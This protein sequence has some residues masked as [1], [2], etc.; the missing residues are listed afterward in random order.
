MFNTIVGAASR[1]GSGSDQMK[2]LL[3]APAPQ[4]CFWNAVCQHSHNTRVMNP[5]FV[6]IR[7]KFGTRCA[8]ARI[9]WNKREISRNYH[10]INEESTKGRGFCKELPAHRR[11]IFPRKGIPPGITSLFTRIQAGKITIRGK[12]FER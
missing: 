6:T 4:Q 10:L 8:N 12:S 11:G 5:R 3:A 7:R 9:T 2:R 1:Y